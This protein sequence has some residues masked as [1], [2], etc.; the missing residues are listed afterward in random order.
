M[1]SCRDHQ[2]P[3]GISFRW[4][5]S[6]A[7]ATFLC[8]AISGLTAV[9][10]RPVLGQDLLDEE[11]TSEARDR[12]Y[13]ELARDVAALEQ[14]L[15]IVKRVVRLVSPTVVHIEAKK[16]GQRQQNYGPRADVEEAGSGVVIELVGQKYVLTNRHVVRN[17]NRGDI[18]VHLNDGRI[19][20]PTKVWEDRPTDVAIMAIPDV[21]QLAPARLGNS[22]EVEIGDLVLAVGSP[23]GLSQ[24]VTYGIISAKGR[25]KL[26]LGEGEGEVEFQNFLQTD[27]AINPGNSGGPLIN[28]RG[29]V[30]GLNTAIASSSGGNEGIGF[31]IPVNT[32]IHIARQLVENGSVAR[33]FLGVNLDDKYDSDARFAAEGYRYVQGARVKKV[34][35]GSPASLVD[36]RAG[37]VILAFDGTR[38][39][40][41]D[42]LINVVGLTEVGRDVAVVLLRD[43]EVLNV[44]VRVG[45]RPEQ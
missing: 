34:T 12:Q 36:I 21:G 14:Q 17:A 24:S 28:L 3:R 2:Y 29:E 22:A 16:N 25:H 37:D 10:S 27:A 38:I 20:R 7:V 43:G 23:F 6:F 5:R 32:A 33:A 1:S 15:N 41:L 40:N 9:P 35:A 11:F 44:N 4:C 30:I 18:N 31:S 19:I 13:N 45:Q 8:V 42:H 26:D 39:K